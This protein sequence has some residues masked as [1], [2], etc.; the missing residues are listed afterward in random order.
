MQ[1]FLFKKKESIWFKWMML[2]AKQFSMSLYTAVT[3]ILCFQIPTIS[4]QDEAQAKILAFPDWSIKED[5]ES[6]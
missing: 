3:S 5:K 2:Q 1:L 6:S 4:S